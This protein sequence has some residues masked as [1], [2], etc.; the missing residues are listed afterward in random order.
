MFSK[1][2]N[3]PWRRSIITFA[4]HCQSNRLCERQNRAIKDF[5]I[6]VLEE[7]VDQRTYIKDSVQFTHK[8]SRSTATK[9]SPFFLK[10]NRQPILPIDINY[11]L[12]KLQE[13]DD[14]PYDLDIVSGS[15]PFNFINKG[16]YSRSGE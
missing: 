12:A 8:V 7:K 15:A 5:L 11:G 13:V 1:E 16:D 6:K 3:K 4:Y 2:N 9:Y 14:K 10:Y